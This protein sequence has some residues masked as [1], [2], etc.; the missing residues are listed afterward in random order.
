[1][2]YLLL[3]PTIL[4]T[5]CLWQSVNH[6]DIETAIRVCGGLE[7]VVEIHALATGSESVICSNREHV[8]L[9]AK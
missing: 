5:G 2:K 9:R 4:L 8:Y 6:N 1:M 3:L 7:H